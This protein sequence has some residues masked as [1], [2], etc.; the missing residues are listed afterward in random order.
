[1]ERVHE[2]NPLMRGQLGANAGDGDRVALAKVVKQL[3]GNPSLLLDTRAH[4]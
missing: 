4:R 3:Q 2:C 1:M